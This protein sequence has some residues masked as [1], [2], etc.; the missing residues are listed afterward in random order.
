MPFES[1]WEAAADGGHR[2]K[3]SEGLAREAATILP[4]LGSGQRLLDFACGK[5]ELTK[6]YARHFAE[7]VATDRAANMVDKARAH[8][9]ENSVGNV[10]I[11]QADNTN[12]WAR[13]AGDFDCITAGQV[14]QYLWPDELLAFIA[15][16]RKRLKPG[17]R[18]VLVD[19]IDYA[20]NMRHLRGIGR[21]MGAPQKLVRSFAMWPVY[22]AAVLLH[23]PP[24]GDGIGH[25]PSLFRGARLV[26]SST[27]ENRYHV[28][29]D[30]GTP[31]DVM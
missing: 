6:H 10:T 23:R 7:C 25:R 16:A 19:V 13:V 26:P 30:H 21:R 5:A 8:L 20:A 3:S 18:L 12:V 27:Y 11:L 4:L 29:Y 24:L 22:W 15:S 31:T 9:K 14:A 2:D 17:G 28:V 1:Y